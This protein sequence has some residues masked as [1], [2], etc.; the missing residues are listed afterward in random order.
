M[1]FSRCNFYEISQGCES[2]LSGIPTTFTQTS[3]LETK[4]QGK[5]S[6]P[7]RDLKTQTKTQAHQ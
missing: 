4:F 6:T 2:T 7:D 1:L 5:F 3:L